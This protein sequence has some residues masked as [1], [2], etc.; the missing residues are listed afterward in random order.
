MFR[1]TYQK[2]GKS[3]QS[4]Y[5]NSGQKWTKEEDE[6]LISEINKGISYED[7]A[8]SHGRSET[9]VKMRA[10]VNSF[11]NVSPE[12]SIE[13]IAS[14]ISLPKEI[15][16]EYLKN[17][18]E[19]KQKKDNE[20]SEKKSDYKNDKNDTKVLIQ[21]KTFLKKRGK[22]TDELDELFDEFMSQ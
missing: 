20:K 11:E 4:S 2:M 14:S 18:Q 15:V 10:I 6:K 1:T 16:E 5:Q 3:S 7:I 12:E 19:W 22:F 13:E 8:M 9:A 21:F 17:K